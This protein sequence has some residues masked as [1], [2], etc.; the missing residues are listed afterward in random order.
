[1]S[2]KKE[3]MWLESL[4]LRSMIW[5]HRWRLGLTYI[6]FSLEMTGSLL[7]PFF[8]GRAIND[9]IDGQYRGL[10]ELVIVHL[11]WVA[12]SYL[13]H[14]FDT[15]TYSAIY[16][17]IMTSILSRIYPGQEVSKWSARSGLAKDLVDFLEYDVYFILEAAYNIF[18]SLIL[19]SI[20]RSPVVWLCL[21]ALVPVFLI[22][23]WYGR[24]M[25]LLQ[26]AKHDELEGQVDIISAG[27]ISRIKDHYHQLQKWQIRISDQEA[28]NFGLMEIIV[29]SV[30]SLALLVSTGSSAAK[31]HAGDLVGIYY[32][33]L[34]F[35][36]GLDTIP[37]TLQRW[38]MLGDIVRRLHPGPVSGIKAMEQAT[39]LTKEEKLVA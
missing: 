23:F 7:R 27:N 28:L 15:R 29:I 16:T 13:R 8:I 30:I 10:L 25:R 4:A 19:L 2:G 6:L 1:M 9:L 12:I 33:I 24:K 32:Y 18:G 5:P 20:Y 31:I 3:Y 14:R 11:S 37:Y 38:S 26:K 22:S 17:A 35:L 21:A 39:G 34:K 36:N